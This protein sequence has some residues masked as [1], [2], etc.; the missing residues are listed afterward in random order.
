MGHVTITPQFAATAGT[1][2]EP[3][4]LEVR[5]LLRRER[6]P[7]VLGVAGWPPMT[8]PLLPAGLPACGGLTRSEEGGLEEVEEF[9]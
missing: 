9:F 4:L 8:A 5:H 2:V 6:L 1:G 7:L 3:M